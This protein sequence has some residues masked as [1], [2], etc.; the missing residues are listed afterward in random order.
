VRERLS[1]Q[2]TTIENGSPLPMAATI[3]LAMI[4]PMPDT[5]INRS[6]AGA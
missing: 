4:G 6:H 3:A 5:L 1:G 2:R